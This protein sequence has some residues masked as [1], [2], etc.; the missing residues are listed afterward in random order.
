MDSTFENDT[1]LAPATPPFPFRSHGFAKTSTRN[2]KKRPRVRARQNNRVYHSFYCR[3]CTLDKRIIVCIRTLA[4][5]TSRLY[6]QVWYHEKEKCEND[7]H[8]DFTSRHGGAMTIYAHRTRTNAFDVRE[9]Y[10]LSA[11]FLWHHHFRIINFL[12]FFTLIVP[13]FLEI[14]P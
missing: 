2:I 10:R 11:A 3:R 8:D 9:T 1:Y 6:T 5:T 4:R 14:L 13:R 7:I 12:F